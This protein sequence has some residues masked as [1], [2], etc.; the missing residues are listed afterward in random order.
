[1][2]ATQQQQLINFSTEIQEVNSMDSAPLENTPMAL[3]IPDFAATLFG[4]QRGTTQK[5]TYTYLH[6]VGAL[7]N[8]NYSTALVYFSYCDREKKRPMFRVGQYPNGTSKL[9]LQAWC[10]HMG[11]VEC[12][13]TFQPKESSRFTCPSSAHNFTIKTGPEPESII[14]RNF[15][16]AASL[17]RKKPLKYN[18]KEVDWDLLKKYVPRIQ[19]LFP[20]DEIPPPTLYPL[21][22][23]PNFINPT[24]IM[25][26]HNC[27]NMKSNKLV[28]TAILTV[29]SNPSTNTYKH[30][31]FS[32]SNS[33]Y[34]KQSTARGFFA[35]KP[36]DK[37]EDQAS[38]NFLAPA[39]LAWINMYYLDTINS[40]EVDMLS[41]QFKENGVG[42]NQFSNCF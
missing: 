33:C 36:Y 19:E 37:I 16:H 30:V 9:E 6:T 3:E 29:G 1:M 13:T 10:C 7:G 14:N 15:D 21:S 42:A 18:S 20:T 2:S 4:A 17:I 41:E 22:D 38:G 28:P 25:F 39:M 32:C 31:C 35:Y 27:K 24:F 8:C 26:H 40:N 34:M 23:G 11:S 5:I 12:P